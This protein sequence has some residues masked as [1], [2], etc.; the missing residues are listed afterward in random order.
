[1]RLIRYSGLIIFLTSLG[2]FLSMFF[3]SKYTLTEEIA[4]EHLK[5]EHQQVLS[6]VLSKMYGQTYL[7]SIPFVNTIKGA[8][9]TYN[10][11]QTAQQNPGN[12]A[13][14]YYPE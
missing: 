3:M 2:I 12:T 5:P 13:K 14:R 7:L 6:P 8:I 1:M 10:E 4:K 9:D 11:E